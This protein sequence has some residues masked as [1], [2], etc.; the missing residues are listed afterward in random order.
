MQHKRV[1]IS[2]DIEGIAGVVGPDQQMVTGFE[3][4]LARKWMTNEVIAACEASFSQGAEEVIV[5]DSH[6]NG[7]NIFLDE[8]PDNVKIIR[9]WPRPLDMMQGI[10]I[11]QYDAVLFIG[12]HS[13]ST[14]QMG[15]MAHTVHGLIIHEIRLNGK[16]ASETVISA[17]TAGHFGVPVV[18]ISGDDAY[19]E[20]AS[21]DL[22]RVDSVITKWTTGQLSALTLKPEESCQK[23]AQ[24]VA[25]ALD[26]IDQYPL[27]KLEGPIEV[28]ITFKKRIN[29][30][31]LSYLSNVERL[32]GYNIRF[33]AKD[34][35]EGSKFI[36]FVGNVM[37]C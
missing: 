19:I 20:V 29:A 18:F 2:A 36:A 11:G 21:R 26:R 32:D 14:D 28:E 33:I 8:M 5:S 12:Y 15:G 22:H 4:E 3:Y 31:L 1:Y 17:A 6:G 24:G 16:V 23:I 10:D 25:A 9:S 37:K 7:Q 27:Y 34:M 30:E 13:G 35:I